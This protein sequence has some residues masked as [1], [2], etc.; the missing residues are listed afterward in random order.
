MANSSKP[1]RRG[2]LKSSAAATIGALGFPTFVP[3]HVLA[4]PGRPG[5]ND[6]IGIGIIGPGRRGAGSQKGQGVLGE[7]A[8]FGQ[9][10][11]TADVYLPRAQ[12]V[13]SWYG[14]PNAYQDYRKLLDNKDVDGVL[15]TTPDHWRVLI[16]IHACQARKDIYAEKCLTLTIREGRKLVEAVNKYKCIFQTG[17]Q[18]RSEKPT[19]LGC[20]LIRN[21]RV[22]KVHTVVGYNYPSPWECNMHAQPTLEG[23]DWD[24]WCGPVEPIP[25]HND[26]YAPRAD[27][28]WLSFRPFSG[29]EMT[30]WGA[31][32]LDQIQWALGMDHSGPA[33]VWV[34]G[35]KY[36]PPTFTKAG[37][38]EPANKRCSHPII[39]YKY[40]DGPV[41][42]LDNG[43]RGGGIFIGDKGKIAIARG[44]LTSDPKELIAEPIQ[45]DEIH[46]YHSDDHMKNWFDGMRTRKP[47][48]AD[49]EIGHRSSTVCHLGNIAR[50]LN[51]KL[52]WDP[53]KEAFMGDDE[54]NTYLD[55]PRRKGYELPEKV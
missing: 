27:P 37:P 20:E 18:Q 32:G 30:G 11:A 49:A 16:C 33:E 26:I 9:V 44:K 54:A 1:S 19:R 23:L 43:P 45:S 10:V 2:F 39:Y 12:K 17:S 51:R 48:V 52:Q 22:G 13:A 7:A 21:G 24:T 3:S 28:G 40:A 8:R 4:A 25:F 14:A 55:R 50:W 29:G 47:C 41:V 35:E 42:K 6:R 36:D 31:H 5:A 53:V 15:V 46:L 34:E 38:R